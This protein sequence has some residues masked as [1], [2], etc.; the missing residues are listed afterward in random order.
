MYFNINDG[1]SSLARGQSS[2][3]DDVSNFKYLKFGTV[4]SI[5]DE[6]SLGRI[7][8]RINGTT[9]TG[10]DK[11][12][13]DAELPYA[14]PMLPKHLQVTPK[15]GEA[16]WV[17]V[18]DKNRQHTDR[19]YIGPVTSQLDKLNYDEGKLSAFRGFS[20][21]AMAPNTNIDDIPQLKGIFP[22]KEDISI[23]GRYNTDITQKVNEI[24]L[25]AGKFESAPTTSNNPYPFI[26]NTKTQAY[27]QIKN[28]VS[29]N[30]NQE[31]GDG[32]KGTITNIVANK[33]NLITHKDGSPRFNVTGQDTLISDDEM[34]K[35][36]EE[37]HQLPFGDVLIEYLKLLKEALFAH[38]HNGN[39]NPATDL[40]AS[41]NKQALAT[42]KSRAEDL[43]KSMLSKNIRI[44]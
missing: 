26:F 5:D 42:F 31:G 16:V 32:E 17:F 40:T 28:D 9:A 38:V 24:V 23:Q 41:G 30:R 39:G 10:G 37:A 18:F 14:Y 3:Y 11:N 2:D 8:V 43:E 1:R 27:I 20:F 44:N 29:L 25:R 35:I 19:L 4:I 36:L 7:K 33:I 12:T 34:S 15:V 21:G 22:N 6:Y 13:I